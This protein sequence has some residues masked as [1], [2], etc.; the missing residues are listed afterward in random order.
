MSKI[1]CDTAC[2][3]IPLYVDKVLSQSSTKL[4]EEHLAECESCTEQVNTLKKD[5]VLKNYDERKPLHKFKN[6]IMRHRILFLLATVEMA[7]FTICYVMNDVEFTDSYDDVKDYLQ[8]DS[9]VSG[10]DGVV[11]SYKAGSNKVFTTNMTGQVVGVKDDVLQ[12][13][14]TIYTGRYGYDYAYALYSD[15]MRSGIV[16]KP[17]YRFLHTQYKN[18]SDYDPEKPDLVYDTLSDDYEDYDGDDRVLYDWASD[19]LNSHM[20]VRYLPSL[21]LHETEDDVKYEIVR[22]YYGRWNDTW[23]DTFHRVLLWEK[24]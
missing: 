5:V 10:S 2:D 17:I 9:P 4:L 22:I 21:K 12:I 8:V 18:V 13:E 11:V 3:L 19:N 20:E 15:I 24:A 1:N 7:L 16:P 23:I 6:Q 14:A